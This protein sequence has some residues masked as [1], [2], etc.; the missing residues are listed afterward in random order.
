LNNGTTGHN[1]YLPRSVELSGQHKLREM[2]LGQPMLH[3]LKDS[4]PETKDQNL[5]SRHDEPLQLATPSP[6]AST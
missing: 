6:K 4:Q 2:A 5:L 1:L 3:G